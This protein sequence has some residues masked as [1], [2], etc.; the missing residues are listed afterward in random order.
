MVHIKKKIVFKKDTHRSENGNG[1][2]G[3]WILRVYEGHLRVFHLCKVA[4]A[5]AD[6]ISMER[7]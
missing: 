6:L 1:T 5:V 3:L 4:L 2:F 7:P